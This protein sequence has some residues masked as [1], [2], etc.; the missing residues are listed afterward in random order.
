[1]NQIFSDGQL[2]DCELTLKDL[3]N[4]AKSFNKILYGIHHH[5]IEYSEG[6][7]A[8]NGIDKGKS[9]NGS[10]DRKPARQTQDLK[11]EDSAKSKGHLKRLGLS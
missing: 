3:H 8:G 6:R 7:T 1:M 4:I 11:K 2:D 10:S 5:R 9:K